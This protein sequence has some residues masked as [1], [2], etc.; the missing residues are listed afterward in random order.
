MRKFFLLTVS[1]FAMTSVAAYADEHNGGNNNG[2]N[3]GDPGKSHTP[4]SLEQYLSVAVAVNYADSSDNDHSLS[5][6]QKNSAQIGSSF[7]GAEGVSNQ[8]QNAGANSALQNSLSLAYVQGCA[9]GTTVGGG[10]KDGSSGSIGDAAA[11]AA[12]LNFGSIEEAGGVHID[13]PHSYHSAPTSA[14]ATINNG[15]YNGFTGAAQ[16]NQ[17]A[18][19]GSLLQNAT[20]LASVNPISGTIDQTKVALGLA[21]NDGSVTDNAVSNDQHNTTSAID[22]SFN[23]MKGVANV[24]QNAAA[25]SLLQ[26]STAISSIEY[27]NCAATD[28]SASAALSANI[29]N[30]NDN[31]FSATNGSNATTMNGSFNGSQGVMQISQNA[32]ANSL[33]QNAASVAVITQVAH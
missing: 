9:C 22:G 4:P 5:N 18:G 6:G 12:A 15:A 1:V 33:L 28:L 13:D 27:C 3:G 26:N 24:N 2:N 31:S 21:L 8:N 32:G 19:A 23:N 29:G 20:A 7:Q 17:N 11:F 16:V 25:N 10:S 30:V 14:S